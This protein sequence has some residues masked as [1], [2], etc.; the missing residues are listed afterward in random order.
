MKKYITILTALVICAG[1]LTGCN[2]QTN[3]DNIVG[4][5]STA[6]SRASYTYHGAVTA[7]GNN[8][9][10]HTWETSADDTIQSYITSPFCTMSI[11]DSENGVYQW[12][13][14]MASSITD[15][16]EAH[17]DDLTKYAVTLPEGQDAGTTDSGYVF[18]FALNPNAK[19]EDGTPIN[20]DSYIYSMKQ[21][22]SPDMHNYRANL[23][24]AGES[25][26]AGAESYYYSGS[27]VN[28]REYPMV[29]FDTVGCYKVD[30][31]TIRYVCQNYIDFNYFLTACTSTWLVYEPLYEAGKDSSGAL[32]TTNYG[33]S[34][35]TTMSYGPYKIE[36]MQADRQITFV[37]NENWYGWE[38]Q[39][40]GMLISYTNF[41]V[42]GKRRQQYQTTRIVINV[43][44]ES[45]MQQA[46]LK[47]E[48][49]EWT[50]SPDELTAYATSD[51]LYKMDQTYT[52][53]FFFNTNVDALRQMDKSKGNTNSVVLSNTNFR[54]AFSLS[55]DRAE[56]V[57]ATAGYKPAY[58]LMNDLYY[59]DIYN[60]P[61]SS[62]RGSDEAMRAVCNLYGVEYGEGTAYPTLK[63]AYDS[64]SGY[65]RT[66]AKALMQMAHDELTAEGLYTTGSDIVIRIGWSK[67]ALQSSDNN[68]IALIN[69]FIN[70]AA[71]G[72]GFGKITFEAVGNLEDR[73][74]DVP[75][76]EYAIG[77]GAWGGAAFY[78]FRNMQVYCDNQQYNIHE[79]ACWDPSTE[80]LTLNV[81]GEDVTMSWRA[82]SNALIGT[83]PYS[84]ADNRLKL[85]ITADLEER[86]LR[87][88]YRIPLCA[89][90]NCFLVSYKNSY[91]TDEYNIMYDFGGFRLLQYHYTDV[92]WD[93]F[94][95]EQ[96][97]LLRYE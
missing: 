32:T 36:S 37:R 45:A 92:E 61:K 33:T 3:P 43:M 25:A 16:T 69:Q 63:D 90:T 54:K 88:Y 17:R 83:G 5:T 48:L 34:M 2:T 84:A 52:Q 10:P 4:S 49:S 30:D 55:I 71:E 58:T 87:K 50:P 85:K 68:Q 62:Y 15:V 31:Y 75:A 27:T 89:T 56:Y 7:L 6:N 9:N 13:Y 11:L 23:Y 38:K 22:L 20:A 24:I 72:T 86:Y 14:E 97:G 46:F 78:P 19:W 57:T 94:V 12:V 73:Y 82:W 35:E 95:A 1:T 44:E 70:A 77:Y 60:D 29:D 74:G 65:N 67:G 18:E 96:G 51:Q 66:E 59:Y 21:L 76:G 28:G 26:L 47:G 64:I 41:E 53:S 8:W 40:D 81:N 91:Y 93:A 80:Q 79:A 42:D 39:E